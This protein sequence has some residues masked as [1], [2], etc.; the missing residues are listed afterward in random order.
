MTSVWLLLPRKQN[1]TPLQRLT[2]R[3]EGLRRIARA[4]YLKYVSSCLGPVWQVLALRVHVVHDERHSSAARRISRPV[5]N[6]PHQR[7]ADRQ[8]TGG[9]RLFASDGAGRSLS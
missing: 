5:S 3:T 9:S 4:K 7:A 6:R 1:W 8:R 2:T